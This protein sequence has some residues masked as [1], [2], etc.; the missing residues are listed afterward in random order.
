MLN[1]NRMKLEWIANKIINTVSNYFLNSFIASLELCFKGFFLISI[2]FYSNEL[3]ANQNFHLFCQNIYKTKNISNGFVRLE[4]ETISNNFMNTR[5]LLDYTKN[6]GRPRP[7]IPAFWSNQYVLEN[8]FNVKGGVFSS[9]GPLSRTLG[10]IGNFKYQPYYWFKAY[11][12]EWA[13]VAQ[14]WI[15]QDD[16]LNPLKENGPYS[17]KSILSQSWGEGPYDILGTTILGPLGP[18]GLGPMGPQLLLVKGLRLNSEG[19]YLNS[20][21][22]LVRKIEVPFVE[23]PESN[24]KLRRYNIF[25]YYTNENYVHTL[26]RNTDLDSSFMV[27]GVFNHFEVVKSFNVKIDQRELTSIM[28]I[29]DFN[30]ETS[31]DRRTQIVNFN[32]VIK[33]EKGQKIAES[34]EVNLTNFVQLIN[35]SLSVIT[36]EIHRQIV[37]KD[38]SKNMDLPYRLIVVGDPYTPEQSF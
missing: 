25:N 33:N 22:H 7:G 6:G 36:I 23:G 19:E 30:Y 20:Q 12:V 13:K 4:Q 16:R 35:P 26:S 37:H 31:D 2:C 27:D 17:N 34:N 21:G 29:P 15:D 38:K 14:Y 10:P 32:L 9:I 11:G 18:L 28:V 8:V 24:S 1:K 3:L 5:K